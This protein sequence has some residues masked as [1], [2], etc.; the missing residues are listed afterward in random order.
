MKNKKEKIEFVKE[1]LAQQKRWGHVLLSENDEGG[2][3]AFTIN[4]NQDNFS[5]P[6]DRYGKDGD[7]FSLYIGGSETIHTADKLGRVRS[8][9]E[10]YDLKITKENAENLICI[11]EAF[12]EVA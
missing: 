8:K 3:K 10:P 12:L 1:Q 9:A 6:L 7:K 5:H 2:R 11:L 4:W